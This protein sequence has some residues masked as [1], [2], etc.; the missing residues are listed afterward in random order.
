M[1]RA[2]SASRQMGSLIN[3]AFARKDAAGPWSDD[4]NRAAGPNTRPSGCAGPRPGLHGQGDFII[5]RELPQLVARMNKLTGD[6]LLS[7][8][9]IEHE[10]ELR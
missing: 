2:L 5:E 3:A 8:E 7:V 10:I 6:D 4:Q 1:E 9:G